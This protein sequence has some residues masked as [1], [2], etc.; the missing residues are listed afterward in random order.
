MDAIRRLRPLFVCTASL[1]FL[2]TAAAEPPCTDGA[3][4][5]AAGMS[6]AGDTGA[7]CGCR[8]GKPC[9]TG[10]KCR[11]ASGT[12]GGRG[13]GA[14][15]NDGDNFLVGAEQNCRK[16]K[17]WPPYPR[18]QENGDCSTQF[19]AA[20]YWPHPYDCWDRSWVKNIMA[21]QT[22]NGWMQA[23]T[24]CR[25]HFDAETHCLNDTG[26]LHL[27][28][29]LQSAPLEYRTIYVEAGD[30]YVSSARRASVESEAAGIA[31]SVDAP[32]VLRPVQTAGRP[33]RE[34]DALRRSELGSMPPPR[35]GISS[36]GTGSGAGSMSSGR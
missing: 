34:V 8:S 4:D 14:F 6:R 30:S 13:W 17:L 2:A 23:T 3:C 20:H 10:I 19:H 11:F 7:I 12:S 32:I 25:Y 27:H 24:L 18:P 26:R 22:A 1:T 9:S 16:G 29:I 28:W 36:V 21:V 33:A 35:I 5:T 15:N 31:G